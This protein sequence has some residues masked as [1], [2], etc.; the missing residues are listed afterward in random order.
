MQVTCLA[1]LAFMAFRRGVDG[2]TL[3]IIVLWS[4]FIIFEGSG[5]LLGPWLVGRC[6]SKNGIRVAGFSAVLGGL[7][8]VAA[9]L[10]WMTATAMSVSA[11]AMACGALLI[12]VYVV[13]EPLVLRSLLRTAAMRDASIPRSVLPVRDWRF[14]LVFSSLLG[15]VPALC[16]LLEAYEPDAWFPEGIHV[17]PHMVPL[18]VLSFVFSLA[19]QALYWFGRE[20]QT[21]ALEDH[22]S[23]R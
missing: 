6:V 1:S 10:V 19:N 4:L 12:A 18:I 14:W 9:L 2:I 11:I 16:F 20:L 8:V 17:V 15:I 7:V 22:W 21:K 23:Q 3:S 5:L 13:H